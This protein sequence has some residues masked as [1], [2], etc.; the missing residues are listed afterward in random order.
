MR[1]EYE[2]TLEELRAAN[3]ELTV[4]EQAERRRAVRILF[5]LVVDEL[6][7]GWADL[8]SCA[9]QAYELLGNTIAMTRQLSV[10]LNPPVLESENFVEILN[11]L[12]LQMETLQNFRV[13]IRA[14]REFKVLAQEIRGLLYQIVRELIFNVIKH[15]RADRA[16][17]TLSAGDKG[18]LLVEV[19]D[20]GQGFDVAAAERRHTGNFGL[21]S[22]RQRLSLFGG[23]M[24]IKSAPGQ[25]TRITL[26]VPL[27]RA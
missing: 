11:W 8:A 26:S 18:Q 19:R 23:E 21:F 6:T 7:E 27:E 12:A 17:V 10:D 22:T 1:E 9:Q 2:T 3:E 4:A 15:A 25:G 5:Q 24:T 16:V 13:E 14:P 20:T